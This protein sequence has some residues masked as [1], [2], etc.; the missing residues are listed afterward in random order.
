MAELIKVSTDKAPAAIGPYSHI[1]W[2]MN[3]DVCLSC[4]EG[5]DACNM[6]VGH[7]SAEHHGFDA[8]VKMI[9][10]LMRLGVFVIGVHEFLIHF[11][12]GIGHRRG[13]VFVWKKNLIG[14]FTQLL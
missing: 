12:I 1:V 11:L 6:G 14:K 9:G 13:A 8:T 2:K 10:E 4:E 5:I 7:Q 3:V